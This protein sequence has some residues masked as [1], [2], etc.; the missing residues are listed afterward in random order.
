MDC[1]YCASPKG[2]PITFQVK[3]F[4]VAIRQAGLGDRKIL[5]LIV[6]S[7]ILVSRS[8]SLG[9]E[10][11]PIKHQ[12]MSVPTGTI[13]LTKSPALQLLSLDNQGMAEGGLS[14]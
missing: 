11:F 14:E 13:L 8:S 3:N 5:Q 2:H 9:R 4:G 12:W 6:H 1:K 10:Q 7:I